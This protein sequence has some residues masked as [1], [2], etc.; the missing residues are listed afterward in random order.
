MAS[1]L[2]RTDAYTGRGGATGFLCVQRAAGGESRGQSA[3]KRG[4]W[5]GRK[6][7]GGP[8]G[9]AEGPAAASL[10]HQKCSRTETDLQCLGKWDIIKYGSSRRNSGRKTAERRKARAERRY[11]KINCIIIDGFDGCSAALRVR[12]R[13]GSAAEL[14][15]KLCFECIQ[16]CKRRL[17]RRAGGRLYALYRHICLYGR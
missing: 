14:C 6:A 9:E 15:R 8:A 4:A 10:R 7:G 12:G 11:E 5:G 1:A 16:R 17:F 2:M 3:R 13:D